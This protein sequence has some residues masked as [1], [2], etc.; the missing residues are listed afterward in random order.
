MADRAPKNRKMPEWM[1][2][3]LPWVVIFALVIVSVVYLPKIKKPHLQNSLAS[4]V[5]EAEVAYNTLLDQIGPEKIPANS[6]SQLT[7][8]DSVAG[9]VVAEMNSSSIRDLFSASSGHKTKQRTSGRK[10]TRKS[11]KLKLPQVS[12]IFVDGKSSQAIIGGRVVVLGETVWGFK[13]VEIK[14]DSVLLEKK[15]RTYSIR[16]GGS[17]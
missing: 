10:S 11:V 7:E 13:I 4:P 2:Q 16:I 6:V 17:S 9:V 5:V 15:G 8:P 12:A 14:S 3:P 1:Y